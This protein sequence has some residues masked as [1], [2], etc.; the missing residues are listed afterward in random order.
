M[1]RPCIDL[2]EGVVKQIVG[3]TLKSAPKGETEAPV[4]NFVAELPSEHFAGLYRDDGLRG[5]H[6]IMLGPGNEAAV[7]A[8]LRAYPGGMQVGGG[9]D[10]TNARRYLDAGASHVIVTSYVFRD[11]RIDTER[12][13]AIVAAAGGRDRLVLDLSCRRRAVPAVVTVTPA[14]SSTPGSATA[15]TAFEYVVVTDRWQKWTDVVVDA[16]TL[17]ALSEHCAEFLVHG[18]SARRASLG[19]CET[20]RMYWGECRYLSLLPRCVRASPLHRWY[21]A[22]VAPQLLRRRPSLALLLQASMSRACVRASR[23]TSSASSG[24]PPRSP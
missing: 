9:I 16:S 23:T 20:E 11:G 15:M 2:H 7:M 17:R 18:A 10:P 1:F 12:L 24:T 21:R 5:G 19:V 6:I 14:S 3:G 22:V 13:G 4:T 8:A